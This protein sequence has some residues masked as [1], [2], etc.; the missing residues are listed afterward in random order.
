MSAYGRLAF[1]DPRLGNWLSNLSSGGVRVRAKDP[2]TGRL[3]WV[4]MTTKNTKVRNPE[5]DSDSSKPMWTTL[6]G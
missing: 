3:T 1:K 5:Y 2:E 6:V 4:T